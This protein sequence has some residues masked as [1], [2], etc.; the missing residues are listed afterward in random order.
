M[1]TIK[2]F[3]ICLSA[4]L[5]LTACSKDEM[6]PYEDAALSERGVHVQTAPVLNPINGNAVIGEAQLKRQK[7]GITAHYRTGDLIPGHTYTLWWVVWNNPEN[8]IAYPG[9]CDAPDF[10]IADQVKVEVMYAAGRK[11]NQRGEAVFNAHL[12]TMDAVGTINDLFGL[13]T[14]GGLHDPMGA[15]VHMV[16]RSHGPAIPGQ[17]DDQLSSYEG[18][19]TTFLPDFTE[20]PDEPGE[21]AD[22]HF[23]IFQP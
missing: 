20:V 11:A 10:A 21:C 6:M 5:C 22:L 8:C 23:A 19:C 12:N 17:V 4:V 18:G 9:A 7:Q 16:L 14:F 1:T 3:L 15:E 2:G 13:P